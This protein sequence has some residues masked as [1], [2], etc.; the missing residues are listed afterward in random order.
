MRKLPLLVPLRKTTALPEL[1]TEPAL[2]DWMMPLPPR[3]ILL[4]TL[5][6]SSSTKAA[7]VS[8]VTLSVEDWVAVAPVEVRPVSVVRVIG[9]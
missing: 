9:P 3:R 5:V 6:P 8:P 1:V 7:E 4:V 2:G